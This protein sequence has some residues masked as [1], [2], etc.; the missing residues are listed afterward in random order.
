MWN[1]INH[2]A[3]KIS[4]WIFTHIFFD[5]ILLSSIHTE[6]RKCFRLDGS[7]DIQDLLNECPRLDA[8]WYEVLRLY[9]NASIARKATFSTFISNKKI[10]KNETI[11]GP[12]R[13]FHLNAEIFGPNITAFDPNRF[14]A[15]KG[16]NHVRGYYPFGGGNTYCPGRFFARSEIYIFVATA[17]KRFD[18]EILEGQELPKVDLEVP[19]SSAMPAM[20]DCLVKLRP[21]I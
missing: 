2:N 1:R 5:P 13:Q 3:H 9:N 20:G 11:I 18:M 10:H 16:L 6:T 7:I 4:F 8:V 12:F 14:L 17:L 19:S 15:N 21:R